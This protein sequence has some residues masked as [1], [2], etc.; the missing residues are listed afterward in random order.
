MTFF[1]SELTKPFC[2]SSPKPVAITVTEI[3]FPKSISSPTPII[4]FAL[5]PV[6]FWICS[7][8]SPI[9][10]IVISSDPDTINSKTFLLPSILLS[11]NK[12]ESNAFITASFAL[13]DPLAIEE[14]I[15]A[16]PLLDNTV[17]ASFKSIF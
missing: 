14:P 10:S 4:I 6:S 11:F 5:L 8:I 7:F 17:F 16:V 3:L 1:T 9:S 13:F 12:G 15:I 2:L